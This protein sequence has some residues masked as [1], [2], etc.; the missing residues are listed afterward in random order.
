M[1]APKPML[2]CVGRVSLH[3]ILP[4]LVGMTIAMV[5][6]TW[7][8]SSWLVEKREPEM[9]AEHR[10]V[11]PYRVIEDAQNASRAGN[12]GTAKYNLDYYPDTKFSGGKEMRT[13]A[14]AGAALAPED[15]AALEALRRQQQVE[16]TSRSHWNCH[17]RWTR[18]LGQN[19]H[20][21]PPKLANLL[22]RYD[23]LHDRALRELSIEEALT[24]PLT[25]ARNKVR[26][27]VWRPVGREDLADHLLSLTSAF[28]MALL[29]DRVLLVNFP[30]ARALFCEPFTR[31]SWI[32]PSSH[33]RA[34]DRFQSLGA[35][36]QRRG[37][38][39]IVR[40][41]LREGFHDDDSMHVTCQ[42]HLKDLLSH[43]QILLVDSPGGFIE[44]LQHNPSHRDR[45]ATM[46]E[47]DS[48]YG[49]LMGHLFHPSNDMWSRLI[50][51]Y[52]THYT[53]D[54]E[55]PARLAINFSP[56]R[57]ESNVTAKDGSS[58]D[59]LS[60]LRRKLQCALAAGLTDPPTTSTTAAAAGPKELVIYY[61]SAG[62]PLNDSS[63]AGP[64]GHLLDDDHSLSSFPSSPSQ[65]RIVTSTDGGVGQGLVAEWRRLLTDIWMSSWSN[66]Y[67]VDSTLSSAALVAHYYRRRASTMLLVVVTAAAAAAVTTPRH[68]CQLQSLGVDYRLPLPET[69]RHCG[70]LRQAW[71]VERRRPL[72]GETLVEGATN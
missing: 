52:H 20:Y 27:L 54:S 48:P 33:L 4:F 65:L 40:L 71:R 55:R 68:E 42:G 31:S 22:A 37:P 1:V 7:Q 2:T 62:G 9:E 70:L 41:H 45:L 51:S 10:Q 35:A 60:L 72:G 21:P 24:L 15:E 53:N 49:P 8:T 12:E 28:L 26:Y 34:L 25:S 16:R 63:A 14:I 6:V 23:H 39:R 67:I 57:E 38:L 50:D 13:T 36:L 29:T 59:Q 43:V 61:A 11:E 44:L 69:V 64:L 47:G 56:R 3:L 17:H 18:E 30:H 58:N 46:F 5:I 19:S 32:F 66:T